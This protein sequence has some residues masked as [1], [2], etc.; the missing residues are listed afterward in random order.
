MI[1]VASAETAIVRKN[2][3]RRAELENI[4]K[5]SERHHSYRDTS[6]ALMARVP[7]DDPTTYQQRRPAQVEQAR[8]RTAIEADIE[9]R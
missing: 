1:A 9:R 2:S 8:K 5:I 7:D 6:V 4:R 3:A